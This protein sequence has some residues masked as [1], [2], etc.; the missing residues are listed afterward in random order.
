MIACKE[1]QF[2]MH[3]DNKFE[4][5]VQVDLPSEPVLVPTR[6][7]NHIDSTMPMAF[8]T[9]KYRDCKILDEDLGQEV[10]IKETIKN[11]AWNLL[12]NYVTEH[13]KQ[14]IATLTELLIKNL[15]T[16]ILNSLLEQNINLHEE[17][18]DIIE[19]Y[20]LTLVRAMDDPYRVEFVNLKLKNKVLMF[21]I[22]NRGKVQSRCIEFE[23]TKPNYIPFELV[24]AN[25]TDRVVLL[26]SLNGQVSMLMN[27]ETVSN[28]MT[29][30]EI[31]YSET[32]YDSIYSYSLKDDE[33]AAFK[34]IINRFTGKLQSGEI[35]LSESEKVQ[36]KPMRCYR[37]YRI[38]AV[39]E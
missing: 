11:A 9:D 19:Q 35:S 21:Q 39:R 7:G 13:G 4:D 14:E 10:L 15:K 22:E 16:D 5:G 6:N 2:A 24:C 31:N 27:D 32:D 29:L 30:E 28:E 26:E 37:T 25:K 20:A 36:L 23:S 17:N 18:N 38:N 34:I 12:N 8:T 1:S 3:V 33:N